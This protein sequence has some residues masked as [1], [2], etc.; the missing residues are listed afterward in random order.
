VIWIEKERKPL[1]QKEYYALRT[2]FGMVEMFAKHAE[3][4]EKRVKG[5]PDGWR[6]MR[7]IASV[8]QKLMEHI[9]ETVPDKKLASIQKELRHT[10]VEI[11]VTPDYSGEN[12]GCCYISEDTLDGLIQRLMN[13][14]CFLCD[15]SG[16]AMKACGLRKTLADAYPWDFPTKGE[17][18]P[19][20]MMRF[21]NEE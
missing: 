7:M 12:S 20:S 21:E 13:A 18:C 5:I 10:V 17:P 6:D 2:L 4:L 9:L 15:K 16:A 3:L 14:E 1:R 8:A 11:K 19:F